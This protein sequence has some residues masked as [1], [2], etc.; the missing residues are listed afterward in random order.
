MVNSKNDKSEYIM[1]E[2]TEDRLGKLCV[3]P[4]SVQ[5][6]MGKMANS[7]SELAKSIN[8]V[9]ELKTLNG[10]ISSL[11]KG[12]NKPLDVMIMGEFST[13]KSSFIN[14]LVEEEIAIV[15][16]KP[17][18]AVIT[19]LCY[20]END[21]ITVCLQDG[22]KKDYDVDSF[23]ALTVEQEGTKLLRENIKFVERYMP[24]KILKSMNIIDSPGLNSLEEKHVEITQQFIGKADMVVWLFDAHRTCSQTEIDAMKNLNPRLNPLVIIN[25]I[26]LLDEDEGETPEIIIQEYSRILKNNKM[27]VLDIIGM[28]AKMAFQGQKNKNLAMIEASN[29]QAFY[30]AYDDEILPNR[31]RYKRNSL[32]DGL[33]QVL[34]LLGKF[35]FAQQLKGVQLRDVDYSGFVKNEELLAGM[36][37][38]INNIAELFLNYLGMFGGYKTLNDFNRL[39]LSSADRTMLGVLCYFG[40]VLE[41]NLHVAI[42]FLEEAA[43]RNDNVA[44]AI[45]VNIYTQYE[46]AEKAKYWAERVR[47]L[48]LVQYEITKCNGE[49]DFVTGCT[50]EK[51]GQYK[52]AIECYIKAAEAGISGAMCRLGL[53]YSEGKGVLQDY[54]EAAKWYKKAANTGV[55]SAMLN[56]GLLY[57]NGKG[58]Q[59]DYSEAAKWYRKAAEGGEDYAMIYIG[60]L[61]LFGDGVNKDSNEAI[62]WFRKAAEVGNQDAIVALKSVDVVVS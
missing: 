35:I 20:G 6:D 62:K 3:L 36:I 10:D 42:K 40:F 25:K 44:Q 41:K 50:Y 56:L 18:T 7:L 24:L 29:M 53:L 28:S 1:V 55:S 33:A 9:V 8:S 21:R 17:T 54:N 51:N 45:L 48:G 58:V 11:I 32:L 59:Q 39:F 19:K 34:F 30:K 49:M 38:A 27:E 16:A 31:D 46:Q 37:D 4:E 23:R 60:Y 52:L 61:Y 22:G 15:D 57:Q 26:D 43:V 12:I 2:S 47:T 13:G 5:M 14:A